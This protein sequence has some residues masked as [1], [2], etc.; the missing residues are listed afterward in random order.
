MDVLVG[1]QRVPVDR[2]VFIELLE[3]SVVNGRA[4]FH[5]ALDVLSRYLVDI[6]VLRARR[7]SGLSG[8]V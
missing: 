2:T 5:R 4:P 6:G 8:A 1:G 7:T 3:N